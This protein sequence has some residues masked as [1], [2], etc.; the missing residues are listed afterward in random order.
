MKYSLKGSLGLALIFVASASAHACPDLSGNYEKSCTVDSTDPGDAPEYEKVRFPN[1]TLSMTKAQDQTLYHLGFYT[2]EADGI[3]RTVSVPDL[4]GNSVSTQA[5][6]SCNGDQ[7]LQVVLVSTLYGLANQQTETYS[8]NPNGDLSIQITNGTLLDSDSDV[9]VP[10]S[11]HQDE[12]YPYPSADTGA[13]PS[14][15]VI[16]YSVT[17]KRI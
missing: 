8:L 7:S 15:D 12:P 3:T 11:I 2:V 4:D 17:C 16:H 14:S 10:H 1:G 5:T 13:S 6:A 9:T